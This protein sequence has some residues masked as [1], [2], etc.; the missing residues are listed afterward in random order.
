[1][2]VIFRHMSLSITHLG[3]G[4]KGNAT[5]LA[6]DT[7]K[8]LIDQGFSGKELERRLRQLEIDPTEIDGIVI[9]HHHGD[10]GGGAAIAN[11]RW[12]IPL[13]SNFRTAGALGL[14]LVS[15]VTLF[16]DLERM[17][18]GTDISLLPVP[19]PHDGADNV[20]FI[21]SRGSGERAAVFTD[22][23]SWTDE[24]IQHLQ[25]CSHISI[26]ANYDH[27]RLWDGP[28]AY[29]LK[30]RISSRGGHLSNQQTGELLSKVVS[31]RTKSIVLTHLSEQNNQ[32]HLAE[33]AVLYHID[34]LFEGDIAISLQEGPHFTHFIGH[35]DTEMPTLGLF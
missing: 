24:I 15:G 11:K 32:P 22:L 6:T 7:S 8:V 16:E 30:E 10:H 12:G 14:D 33:S 4:S 13:F 28:Y 35:P 5:L 19:V 29:S 34:E 17:E 3:T 9:S 27:R 31:E 26:E 18:I 25:G 20:G 2:L 23:G 21:V 1:M